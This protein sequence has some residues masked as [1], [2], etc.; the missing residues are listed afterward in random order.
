MPI[1]Q[2]YGRGDVLRLIEHIDALEAELKQVDLKLKIATED[3][4][5]AVAAADRLTENVAQ[6]QRDLIAERE[7]KK[8]SLPPKIIFAIE[9]LRTRGLSN[10]EIYEL[11]TT[12]EDGVHASNLNQWSD[13]GPGDGN[14]LMAALVN[15]YTVEEPIDHEQRLRIDIERLVTTWDGRSRYELNK[16]LAERITD[17][18]TE[19]A[20]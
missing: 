13:T 2:R 9:W 16:D 20:K 7:G 19:I 1:V 12:P 17:Y 4:E 11:S 8:V 3:E 15:G 18:F 6:M 10:E 14:I 5:R